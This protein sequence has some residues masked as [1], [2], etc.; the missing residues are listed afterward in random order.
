M[1]SFSPATGPQRQAAML[2]SEHE[3]TRHEIPKQKAKFVFVDV[4]RPSQP[5]EVM[6]SGEL[7]LVRLSSL[8]G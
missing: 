1:S 5:N 7:L 3:N 2:A 8:S 6:S 4:L